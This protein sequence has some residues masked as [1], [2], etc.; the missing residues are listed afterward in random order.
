[1]SGL[2]S[3]FLNVKKQ[4]HTKKNLF[5]FLFAYVSFNPCC[6]LSRFFGVY[7]RACAGN[8]GEEGASF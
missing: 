2:V 6:S 8:V 4:T 7:M 1:M 5:S 3:S